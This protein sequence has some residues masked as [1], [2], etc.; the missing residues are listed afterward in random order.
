MSAR[1]SLLLPATLLALTACNAADPV[2]N[3]AATDL[4]K[5]NLT[6]AVTPAAPVNSAGGEPPAAPPARPTT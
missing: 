2:A 3:L 1:F 5:G 6:A 4:P